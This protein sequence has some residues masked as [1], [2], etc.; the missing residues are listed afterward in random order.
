MVTVQL[1]LLNASYTTEITISVISWSLQVTWVLSL[2]VSIRLWN[3]VCTL[4]RKL[5]AACRI[6]HVAHIMSDVPCRIYHVAYLVSH[7][8]CRI[9]HVAVTY[10]MCTHATHMT[11]D[12]LRFIRYQTF[13]TEK[14]CHSSNVGT[15]ILATTRHCGK[16]KV[17]V[18]TEISESRTTV[19]LF[20]CRKILQLIVRVETI[21]KH[22]KDICIG[23]WRLNK[24]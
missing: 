18:K 20:P 10:D 1:T 15:H 4:C 2:L 5:N 24:T 6:Y 8:S 16:G 11:G 17:K 19:A 3:V 22:S 9:N 13:L 21:A 14:V 23:I 7:L 12:I